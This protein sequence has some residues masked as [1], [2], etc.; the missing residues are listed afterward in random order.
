MKISEEMRFPHPV[1][2]EVTG[3]FSTGEFRVDFEVEER[4]RDGKLRLAYLCQITEPEIEELVQK[5]GA[6]AGLFVTC[7]ETYF[8]QLQPIGLGKGE[9]NFAGG[10]LYGRVVLRPIIW[11]ERLP[12]DWRPRNSHPEFGEVS[13]GKHKLLGLGPETVINVGWDKLQPLET[14]FALAVN[15]EMPEGRIDIDLEAD[16]IRIVVARK[17]HE[18]INLYRG[19]NHGR[20]I[21]LNAVY[22][23]AIME[24]LRSLSSERQLY[25][26]RRW[27]RPFVAK[28]DHLS[29]DLSD[30]P[31]LQ[32]A[33]K[34]LS[35]PYR[36]LMDQQAKIMS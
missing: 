24:V 13:I 6:H 9:L 36:R 7:L 21:L 15:D 8:N 4:P 29:I 3:D 2:S 20:A 34:L 26:P 35:D 18:S 17:T 16:K 11:T 19:S 30:P 32:D 31:I 27:Y 22:L 12:K 33:Q 14:I 23:P 28:C 25:E 10:L 5:R 1:L